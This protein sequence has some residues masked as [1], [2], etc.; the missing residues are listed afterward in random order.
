MARFDSA[1]VLAKKLILK[2]G[3]TASLKRKVDAAPVDPQKPW[4]PGAPTLFSFP[5][6]V[7]FLNSEKSLVDGTLLKAGSQLALIPASD[8][9]VMVPDASTDHLVRASGEKW[10]IVEVRTLAPNGQLILHE[11]EVKK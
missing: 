10:T 3:E 8:L 4:E 2:N 7:V 11:C 5:A 9:G 6:S 1:I